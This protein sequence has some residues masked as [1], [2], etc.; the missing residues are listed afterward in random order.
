M[1]DVVLVGHSYSGIHAGRIA[2]TVALTGETDH[3]TDTDTLMAQTGRKGGREI[4]G[5]VRGGSLMATC[6]R[7]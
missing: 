3:A 6:R 7:N 4:V 5:H 2:R 1:R